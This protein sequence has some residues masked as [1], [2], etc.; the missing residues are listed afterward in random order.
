MAPQ[1]A[2]KFHK[3]QIVSDADVSGKNKAE[4][5][6]EQVLKIYCLGLNPAVELLIC[7]TISPKHSD[8]LS[9]EEG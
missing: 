7:V 5:L 2:S 9:I 4:C 3:L 1:L 8:F 6:S